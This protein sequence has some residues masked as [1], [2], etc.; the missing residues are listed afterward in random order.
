MVGWSA[1]F[2]SRSV[3]CTVCFSQNDQQW[4]PISCD[5]SCLGI[6][7]KHEQN[8][9]YADYLFLNCL[10]KDLGYSKTD[11]LQYWCLQ[12]PCRNVSVWP[13][14]SSFYIDKERCPTA[15]TTSWNCWYGRSRLHPTNRIQ[16]DVGTAGFLWMNPNFGL[17]RQSAE[18]P[19]KIPSPTKWRH[20]KL[21]SNNYGKLYS[22]N[23]YS[24]K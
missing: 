16:P 7:T 19:T 11:V 18:D 14:A 12:K 8:T 2:E 20:F 5:E 9:K 6:R 3:R 23:E 1:G 21:N 22:F 15:P 4:R 13:A 17:V 10:S 24:L